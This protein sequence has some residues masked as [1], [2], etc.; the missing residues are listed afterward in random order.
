MRLGAPISEEPPGEGILWS[1]DHTLRRAALGGGS[2]QYQG[3]D[4]PPPQ[5]P[6]HLSPSGKTPNQALCA[7]TPA[8][9]PATPPLSSATILAQLVVGL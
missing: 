7:P 8:L 4:L 3:L 2:S 5:P 6:P 1:G 9:T